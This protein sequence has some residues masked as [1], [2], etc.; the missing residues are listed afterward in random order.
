MGDKD[1]RCVGLTT[2]RP[3]CADCLEIWEPG[4]AGTLRACP[5]LYRACFTVIESYIR[6]YVY[7]MRNR[8]RYDH[9]VHGLA[10]VLVSFRQFP[11]FVIIALLQLSEQAGA[12]WETSN[13]ALH[14]IP[15][16]CGL[17]QRRCLTSCPTECAAADI[18]EQRWKE[19]ILTDFGNTLHRIQLCTTIWFVFDRASSM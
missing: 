14:H 2:L 15:D 10:T 1:G 7:C 6:W 9:C 3:T 11:V 17:H 8:S 12:A 5:G 16:T 19:R 18:W 13:T 4:R